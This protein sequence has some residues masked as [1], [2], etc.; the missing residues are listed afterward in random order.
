M[1]TSADV[2]PLTSATAKSNLEQEISRDTAK[3]TA[4]KA[5]S[6][7]TA[8]KREHSDIFKSFGKPRAN[9]SRENTD[10][11]LAASPAPIDP[12][13]VSTLLTMF[14]RVMLN[15]AFSQEAP[16]VK[17]DGVIIERSFPKKSTC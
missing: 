5:A 14:M 12:Q 15:K 17:Q 10:S 3:D 7:P 1:A 8:V 2:N 9:V 16:S 6:R 13:S 4:K 11:S